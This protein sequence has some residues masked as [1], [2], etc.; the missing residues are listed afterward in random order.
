VGASLPPGDA[1]ETRA[2][3]DHARRVWAAAAPVVAWLDAHVGASAER[4][5]ERP[6]RRRV[7]G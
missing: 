3:L 6:E 7:R 4:E 1:L 5:P 2:P